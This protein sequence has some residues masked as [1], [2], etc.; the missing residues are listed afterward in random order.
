MSKV[1]GEGGV[2]QVLAL[3]FIRVHMNLFILTFLWLRKMIEKK[4][5]YGCQT[6]NLDKN[7]TEFLWLI[8]NLH[9]QFSNTNLF[10]FHL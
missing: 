7:K 9:F 4:A 1:G 8:Y 2:L 3:G 5:Y 10:L 6:S